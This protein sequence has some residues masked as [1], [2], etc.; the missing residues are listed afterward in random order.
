M[1]AKKM[2]GQV[3]YETTLCFQNQGN[4]LIPGIQPEFYRSQCQFAVPVLNLHRFQFI[5]EK[6]ALSFLHKIV[7]CLDFA[8][9]N[10]GSSESMNYY[11]KS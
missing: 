11:E 10:G 4:Y 8:F 3:G 2:A 6:S 5:R 1:E 7:L 9:Q